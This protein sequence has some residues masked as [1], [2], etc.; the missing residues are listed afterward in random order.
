M[1]FVKINETLYPATIEGNTSNP[2]WDNRHTKAI[3]LTIDYT[4]ASQ[5]FINNAKWSI[6]EISDTIEREYDN[7]DF[8]LAGDLIDH[9]DG[10]ITAIMGKLTDLEEAYELVFGGTGH[11]N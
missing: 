7:S 10:T 4:T 11:D 1:I 5:L 8:I 3:T 6:V 2:S 9:R